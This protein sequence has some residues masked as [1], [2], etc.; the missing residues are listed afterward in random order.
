[1]SN[2]EWDKWFKHAEEH[3]KN[4]EAKLLINTEKKAVE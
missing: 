2:K 3:F 4:H 1:M